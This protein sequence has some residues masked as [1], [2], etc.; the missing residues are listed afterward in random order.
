MFKYLTL[1]SMKT[2]TFEDVVDYQK[3]DGN[4]TY[5]NEESNY[6][7]RI[8][9]DF[10]CGALN[11]DT[12]KNLMGGEEFQTR[13]LRDTKQIYPVPLVLLFN[14]KEF[15]NFVYSFG[16]DDWLEKNCSIYPPVDFKEFRSLGNEY[17]IPSWKEPIF[18]MDDR[19]NLTDDDFLLTSVLGISSEELEMILSTKYM[20][21]YPN[22]VKIQ[23][24]MMQKRAEKS[25][26]V[27]QVPIPIRAVQP[28]EEVH[29]SNEME[30]EVAPPE[31]MGFIQTGYSQ[32]Y[33]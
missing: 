8:F 4:F 23:K 28:M 3:G 30:V 29:Q 11:T 25:P 33:I 24:T 32:Q 22:Y 19:G 17:V 14:T 15:R 16:S 21:G 5:H 31:D 20:E 7:F 13:V 2:I 12:I 9:D 27:T 26:V 6:V 18:K 1:P 10:T